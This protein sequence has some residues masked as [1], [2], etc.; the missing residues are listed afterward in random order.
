M[1]MHV[2]LL[3]AINVGGRNLVGMSNLRD[4]FAALGLNDARSLLQSGNLIFRSN[5]RTGASLERF[6]E[7]ETQKRLGASVDYLVRT[8]D[9]LGAIITRNPFPQEAERD[10]GHLLVMF[11]KQAPEAK[12]VTELQAAIKGPEYLHA[13]GKQL[14]TVY[15]AGVGRSKLTHSMI[16]KKLDA[17]GTARNWNTVLKLA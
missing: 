9:E 15:P 12:N 10:P 4:M 11:L 5:R 2:A 7:V 1:A 6:L 13:D 17:R 3:R 8:A 16:E 14:Y